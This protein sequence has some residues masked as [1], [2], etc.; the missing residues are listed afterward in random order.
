[1]MWLDMLRT[2]MAAPET[3]RLKAMRLT[4]LG[5]AALLVLTIVSLAPLR[6]VIGNG[7]GGSRRC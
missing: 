3:P 7:A 2:P 4:I 6:S 1:M 5:C